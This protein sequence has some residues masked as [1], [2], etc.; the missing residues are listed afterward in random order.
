MIASVCP[1]N[2][3]ISSPLATSHKR[4]LRSSPPETAFTIG[5]E[6]DGAHAVGVALKGADLF[7]G[8]QIPQPKGAV[9][10]GAE[11]ELTIG[12]KATA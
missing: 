5:G 2:A 7:A 3:A 9:A 11:Q 12:E 10:A 4:T 6:G 1:V 8:L